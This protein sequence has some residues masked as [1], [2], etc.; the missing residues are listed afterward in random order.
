M[1]RLRARRRAWRQ[2]R[3]LLRLDLALGVAAALI[4]LL[5]SPGLAITGL[6]S[7]GILLACGASIAIERRR[8]RA[9]DPRSRATRPPRRRT[10]AQG[11]GTPP[12]R[13]GTRSTG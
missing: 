2:R 3:R 10:A 5:A 13:D 6:L 12:R 7:L 4:I 9:R 8:E 1:E 11:S